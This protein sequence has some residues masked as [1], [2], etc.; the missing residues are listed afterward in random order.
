MN[1]LL[2][3]G[4][5]QSIFM[6]FWLR[7][8][9]SHSNNPSNK[10]SNKQKSIVEKLS[11]NLFLHI[12][13]VCPRVSHSQAKMFV[14][15]WF[16]WCSSTTFSVQRVFLTWRALFQNRDY[17]DSCIIILF[18]DTR[19]TALISCVKI[20]LFCTPP[21]IIWMTVFLKTLKK[22]I[23][24]ILQGLIWLL[25]SNKIGFEYVEQ[26]LRFWYVCSIFTRLSQLTIMT[27]HVTISSANHCKFFK[28]L[29]KL[30][31]IFGEILCQKSLVI[32]YTLRCLYISLLL[33]SS[34][35]DATHIMLRDL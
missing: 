22:T 34:L 20:S 25:A 13:L 14:L 30:M 32:N 12:V 15:L 11:I 17:W 26:N 7:I 3:L 19:N 2:D 1:T 35:L 27:C 10:P 23:F 6:V 8:G 5:K 29:I 33:Y 18:W 24:D 4:A 16:L 21:H 31:L 9:Q 28:K